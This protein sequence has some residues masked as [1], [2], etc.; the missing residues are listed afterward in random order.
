MGGDFFLRGEL[1]YS[2]EN[3][4]DTGSLRGL[5]VARGKSKTTYLDIPQKP[6]ESDYLDA[7]GNLDSKAYFNAT[8]E[9]NRKV[10]EYNENVQPSIVMTIEAEFD[11]LIHGIA[12]M[13]NDTLCPNKKLTLADGTT[14]TVLDTDKAPIG[15]DADKTIGA[16]LFVRRE[17]SRYTEKTVTVLDD[18]GKPKPV[19]VYQYNEENPNDHYSLYTTDQLEVNPELLRDPSK[20]PLSANASSGHVDGYTLDLCQDLLAKWQGKFGTMDPN[21]MTTYNFCDYYGAMVGQFSTL[22]N[23]WKGI[24]D[25]QETTVHSVESARQNEMGVSTNE[26]LA[27]LIK[28]QQCY[29]ASSRYITVVDEMIEHLIT[30]L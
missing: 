30:R 20:L 18:D 29:N 11:Q 9:Y 23:V 17:T 12:T 1:S 26:E 22:G 28:Y 27:D 8:E 24:I 6:D 3:D 16:E 13:V 5:L 21:S 14:I 25:N 10:E 7:D 19:T 15:D 2:S 4:T